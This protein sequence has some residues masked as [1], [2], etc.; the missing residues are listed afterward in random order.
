MDERITQVD[1]ERVDDPRILEK[2]FRKMLMKVAMKLKR[3]DEFEKIKFMCFFIP[4]SRREE[5]KST[6][7]LIEEMEFSDYLSVDD[8]S[9]L[10][11]CLEEINRK[12]LVRIVEGYED[13][14]VGPVT[15]VQHQST[16]VSRVNGSTVLPSKQNK[17][18][19]A[20]ETPE[21]T[22]LTEEFEYLRN[23]LGRD[24]RTLA[25]KFHLSETDIDAITY[26]HS[27]D[28]KE[29]STQAMY[30]W[31]K[32]LGVRADR[33]SLVETLRKCRLNYLADHVE[34]MKPR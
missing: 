32:N 7:Q 2:E 13:V 10:K 4:R 25:R 31:K 9:F 30:L 6:L 24:W 22:D 23:N 20:Q 15:A 27:R 21:G 19:I 18:P 17:G 16:S 5:I 11:D 33:K 1:A 8:T 26:N 3:D 34:E 14:R 12:D 29:Q 28:L